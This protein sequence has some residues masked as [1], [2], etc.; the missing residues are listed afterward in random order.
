MTRAKRQRG[1]HRLR[2]SVDRRLDRIWV[3]IRDWR[4]DLRPIELAQLA[5]V[6]HSYTRHAMARLARDG[7]LVV[8]QAAGRDADGRLTS[9]VY[10]L[11]FDL[12][13]VAPI[14][15]G[16]MQAGA[17]GYTDPNYIS[18]PSAMERDEWKNAS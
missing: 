16:G 5:E 9:A 15:Q 7:I 18:D 10:E 3:V 11:H 14:L 2:P 13:P 1:Y 12:G 8:A 6:S 17:A 4:T